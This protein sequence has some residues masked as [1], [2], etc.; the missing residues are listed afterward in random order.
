MITGDVQGFDILSARLKGLSDLAIARLTPLLQ[1]AANRVAD[2]MRSVLP[3]RFRQAVKVDFDVSPKGLGVGIYITD[4][5]AR[6]WAVG[7][8]ALVDVR[9][10]ARIESLSF[11]KPVNPIKE[12]VRGHRRHFHETA[13]VDLRPL[14]I[15]GAQEMAAIVETTVPEVMDDK[16]AY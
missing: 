14:V 5:E 7:A 2:R 1:D 13:H 12:Q 6:N 16:N 11:G 15:E 9:G 3:A 8:N 4:P 10:Y